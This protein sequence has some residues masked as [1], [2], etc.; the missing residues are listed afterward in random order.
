MIRLICPPE[1]YTS[2]V[3][4]K[5]EVTEL[6]GNEVFLYLETKGKQFLARVDPRTTARIGNSISVSMNMDNMH[7][8]DKTTERAIR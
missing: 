3:D 6:M 4:C 8:F 7:L 5:V 2:L 1:S